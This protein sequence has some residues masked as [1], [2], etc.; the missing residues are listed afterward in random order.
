MIQLTDR[1]AAK[2]KEI[3]EAEGLEN[4]AVRLKV[5]AGGCAGFT[6]DMSFDSQISE[7]DEAIEIDD[8]TLVIDPLSFQYM[9]NITIDW[10]DSPFGGGFKFIGGEIKSTCGCGNSVSY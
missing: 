3:A 6:H 10:L 8:I 7:L 9:E 5:I 4:Q 2:I 1:A